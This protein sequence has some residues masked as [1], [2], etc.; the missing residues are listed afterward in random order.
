M[1][2]DID[3]LHEIICVP[4]NVMNIIIIYCTF[5]HPLS[6]NQINSNFFSL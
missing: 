5:E 1:L 4:A 3:N 2:N 6:L